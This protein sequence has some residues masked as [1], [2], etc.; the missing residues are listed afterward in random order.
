VE[1]EDATEEEEVDPEAVDTDKEAKDKEEPCLQEVLDDA[2]AITV[3]GS[4]HLQNSRLNSLHCA[5]IALSMEQ[6]NQ[7]YV[8]YSHLSINVTASD[9]VT[10]RWLRP[11]ISLRTHPFEL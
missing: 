8:N 5:A 11:I 1:I 10:A 3:P 2:K 9:N 6:E 7:M 4:D